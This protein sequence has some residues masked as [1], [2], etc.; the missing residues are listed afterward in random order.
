MIESWRCG[1]V[2]QGVKKK[3]LCRGCHGTKF[4]MMSFYE[5]TTFAS[6]LDIYKFD[7]EIID[8]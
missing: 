6:A 3:I 1:G 2:R 5:R 4:I 8:R 7:V